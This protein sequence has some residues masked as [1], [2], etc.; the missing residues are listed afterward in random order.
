MVK[1][2]ASLN[3]KYSNEWSL[4]NQASSASSYESDSSSNTPSSISVS[5]IKNKS[6]YNALFIKKP[7]KLLNDQP[8]SSRKNNNTN[9]ELKSVSATYLDKKYS[10]AMN[11]NLKNNMTSKYAIHK[12]NN[13]KNFISNAY[14]NM[15][16]VKTKVIKP[17][18]NN[19]R[20]PIEVN[21]SIFVNSENKFLLKKYSNSFSSFSLS[22]H[23]DISSN[24][25]CSDSGY[26]KSITSN[27]SENFDEKALNNSTDSNPNRNNG[28]VRLERP[29]KGFDGPRTEKI[30]TKIIERLKSAVEF[31]EERR[32]LLLKK[33]SE[34]QELLQVSCLYF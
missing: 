4:S 15:K 21:E 9:N 22:S 32:K 17:S 11:V 8:P 34:A 26:T 25:E 2:I 6:N 31:S 13:V 12:I 19:I 7:A 27:S 5:T 20:N 18:E 29:S 3:S 33:F 28:S 10:L 14:D 23:Q 16:D 24:N 30:N 1:E